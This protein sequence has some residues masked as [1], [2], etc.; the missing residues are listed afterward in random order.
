MSAPTT[1][2]DNSPGRRASASRSPHEFDY[3][4]RGL[5]LG[6]GPDGY[7]P[8]APAPPERRHRRSLSLGP[9]VVKLVA[10]LLAAALVYWL[11]QA[12]VAQPFLVPGSAMSPTLQSGDRVLVVKAGFLESPVRSGQIIVIRPPH[13]LPCTVK[14]TGTA[15]DLLLRVVALPG[16]T[17][18]SMGDTI[19]VDGRPLR[20]KGW[21]SPR[22]GPVGSRP[23]SSTALGPNQYFVLG[24]NR[25]SACDSREFG[26][27]A[28]SAIVGEAVATVARDHH[29]YLHKL[30]A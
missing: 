10:F 2:N 23:I 11:I 8:A 28:K 19:F 9:I 17:I 18:W 1:Q 20:E 12:F 16:Q 21:Y 14:G 27:V 6:P 3:R 25:A 13:H 22:H 26:P 15:G 4:L 29:V 30:P 24:D 5:I 7:V